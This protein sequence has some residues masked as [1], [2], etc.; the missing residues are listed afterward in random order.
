MPTEQETPKLNPNKQQKA[1]D[2]ASKPG[3][4]GKKDAEEEELSPE[5]QQLKQELDLLVERVQDS[6]SGVQRLALESLRT[7]IRSSTTSMTSVPKPLKFLRNHY[8]K[9][10]QFYDSLMETENKSHL[11]DVL[12]VLAMTMGKEGARESLKYKLTGSKEPVGLWGHEY[13]R[14]LSGEI[15]QEYEVRQSEGKP[16]D[17]LL[18]L[19][20]EIVPFDMAHNAEP[21][22]CDLLLEVDQ[23]DKIVGYVEESNYS[24]VCLYL[25]G[26]S[27]YLPEPQDTMILRTCVTM[28]RKVKQ[29]PDAMRVAIKIGDTDLIR[30]I[31]EGCD[32]VSVRKQ[33]AFMLARQRLFTIVSDD[34]IA[35][36]L[37]H[38]NLS[39]SFLVLAKDLDILEPKTPDDIYKAHLD[40]TRPGFSANVDSARQNLAST[41]VSAFVNA[42]FGQDKLMTEEGNKWLYKNKEHGMM[43]AAA[44]LGMILLWDVDGGLSQIDKYLYSS[45]DYVKAGALLAVGVVNSGVRNDCDPALALLTEYIE[46]PSSNMRTGAILGLG[47]AYAGTMRRDVADLLTPVLEDSAASMEIVSLAGL[48]TGL[49]FAGSCD[50]DVAQAIMQTLLEKDETALNGPYARFLML[51]LGLLYLGKQGAADLTLEALKALPGVP[52]QCASLI[53]ETCAYAGTGNVLKV[54]K[55][56][57]VC[58]D[59]LEENNAH[60]AV[61]VLGI[62]LVAMG[63]ELGSEMAL[64]TF[65]HLLQYGEPVIRRAVPL[66]LGLISV[67]HPRIS[68]MDTLSKLSH[69]HDVDV[70][71]AA[72][73]SLGLIGAG[74]NNARI[75]GMLRALASYY[76][77]DA[78]HLFMVRVAQGLLHMG[79]GTI[80]LSPFHSDR[81]LM[82]P[83]AV[84]GLLIVL[85]SCLDLKNLIL[86]R[87][88][89]LL[90]TLVCAMFPRM[91][92]TFDEDLKPLPVP[93][94]VGQA[95]DTVGQAGKPKTITGFQ[96]HTTPVLLGFLDRAELATDDYIPLTNVLEGFVI[97]RP[98]PNAPPKKEKEK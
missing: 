95:V 55:M 66:A 69:D 76:Y 59:H 90:Y 94:R 43:S 27:H 23:L 14:N 3:Q 50:A 64:R 39:E 12:S 75:A 89:Y 56:L 48:T 91:L 54:Q 47:L 8:P 37:N 82:S 73:L 7:H 46:N 2:K 36:I 74:T 20:D 4:K 17:D 84:A 49:V 33:L 87:A 68:V 70:A 41:F 97:L 35:D 98:N 31:F 38:S 10:T 92:M 44:S 85:H 83:V 60:Q 5:D 67:S 18:R 62:S 81:M 65:D 77:K 21:E 15:A 32:D 22:A 19:V 25:G 26:C 72:I 6:D 61:A 34:A 16:V 79:K 24:R 63:E 40:N 57:H 78:N 86:S 52:G 42:G 96:T 93:V 30:T 51:G 80:T 88:H 13:V 1:A 45:E 11:S 58:S 53:V 29:H 9:L 71:Q 28:Y